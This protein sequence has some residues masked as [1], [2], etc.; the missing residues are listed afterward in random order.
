MAIVHRKRNREMAPHLGAR[1]AG[2][3]GQVPGVYCRDSRGLDWREEFCVVE[4]HPVRYEGGWE[5]GI[6]AGSVAGSFGGGCPVGG[7]IGT[8]RCLREDG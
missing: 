6:G 5:D 8:I 2:K 4:C 7:D 3:G 1:E